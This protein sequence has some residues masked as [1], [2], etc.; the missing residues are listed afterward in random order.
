[1]RKME[2]TPRYDIVRR[3]SETALFWLEDASE[4]SLAKLRVE[5]LRSFWPGEYQ[6]FDVATKKVVVDTAEELIEQ[7]AVVQVEEVRQP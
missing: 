3:E 5:Q 6:I 7:P 4:L 1:M 2:A